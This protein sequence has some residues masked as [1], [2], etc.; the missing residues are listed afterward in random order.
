VSPST[1]TLGT[2][3]AIVTNV[4]GNNQ[5]DMLDNSATSNARL[6]E[7]F[8]GASSLHL[9]LSFTRNANITPTS[10][11]QGL[12][13]SLGANGLSQN[14]QANRAA[15]IRLFNDGSYRLDIGAQNGDGTFASGPSVTSSNGFGE[16]GTTFNTNSLDIYAYAGATGG[17]TLSYT[18][19]DNLTHI[20][21]PHSFQVFIN[22]VLLSAGGPGTNMTVDGDY[23]FQNS[24]FYSQGT[25]GRLGLITGG[26]SAVTGIDFLVDNINLSVI[27]EPSTVA[28]LGTSSLLLIGVLRRTRR[29]V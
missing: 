1:P 25:L 24:S 3:G 18:G 2:L 5:V 4:A 20:L 12:Y 8:T 27:P 17:S 16:G 29:S 7:D 9:S 28:L 10:S 26:S 23:G 14:T 19:P 22:G 13:V 21:D 11:T 6:E 15:D